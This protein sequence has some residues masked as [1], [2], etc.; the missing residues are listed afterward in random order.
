MV[1]VCRSISGFCLST[2]SQL[3]TSKLDQKIALLHHK[4]WLELDSKCFLFKGKPFENCEPVSLAMIEISGVSSSKSAY[5]NNA[6]RKKNALIPDFDN[7]V[8]KMSPLGKL[9]VGCMGHLCTIFA[10]FCESIIISKQKEKTKEEEK[11][12]H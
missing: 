10:I 11:E 12:G 5:C 6:L 3:C 4:S 9:G 7:V 2:D 8:C 1:T